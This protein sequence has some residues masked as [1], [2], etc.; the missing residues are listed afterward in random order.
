MLTAR[1]SKMHTNI[2]THTLTIIVLYFNTRPFSFTIKDLFFA[3]FNSLLTK[4]FEPPIADMTRIVVIRS[5]DK[6]RMTTAKY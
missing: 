1:E 3:K 6:F 4:Y 5:I 2:Q